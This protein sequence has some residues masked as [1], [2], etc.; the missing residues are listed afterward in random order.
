MSGRVATDPDAAFERMMANVLRWG[1]V[2]SVV[3][4]L[5]GLI[6]SATTGFSDLNGRGYPDLFRPTSV[7]QF[8]G[9]VLV[10]GLV[11][12]VLTPVTRVGMASALFARRGDRT[13]VGLTLLVLAVLLLTVVAG[14]FA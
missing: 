1:V 13:Y 12:L 14:R 3:L 7:G 5:V 2:C 11:V 9:G 10:W 8:G 6:L 4:L